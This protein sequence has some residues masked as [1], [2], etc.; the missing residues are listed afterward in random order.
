[1]APWLRDSEGDDVFDSINSPT[2][3][4]TIFDPVDVEQTGE[5]AFGDIGGRLGGIVDSVDSA[6][7]GVGHFA[8]GHASDALGDAGMTYA[9][10]YENEDLPSLAPG[11]G[12]DDESV[13]QS[14]AGLKVAVVIATIIG[15]LWAL[16]PYARLGAE[17]LD[18]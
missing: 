5:A 11:D 12:S 18:G 13:G 2:D 8:G 17:V 10:R 1:M 9:E 16:S 3:S 4:A 7:R 14:L 15:V 6:L